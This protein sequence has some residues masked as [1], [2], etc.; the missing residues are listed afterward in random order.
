V[1]L[2]IACFDGSAVAIGFMNHDSLVDTSPV[3]ALSHV[4]GVG[5]L[6]A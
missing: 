3:C 1:N 4:F 6:D 2:W 5:F